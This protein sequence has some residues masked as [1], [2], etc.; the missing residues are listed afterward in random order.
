MPIANPSYYKRKELEKDKT[1]FLF[2]SMTDYNRFVDEVNT[3][4][5]SGN[6][7]TG[8]DMIDAPNTISAKASD[9]SWYGTTDLSLIS[10]NISS[11]LFPSELQ[12]ISSSL[13]SR[14]VKVDVV[15]LDQQKAIKFTEKEVGIFSFDLASLGLIPVYEFYSPL[16]KKVVSGN[17]VIS[18]K[19]ASPY[20]NNLIFYFV[21]TPKIETHE[22]AYNAK[23]GGYY[24]DVL[25]RIVN[26][27][28][29][30]ETKEL[31]F[32]YEGKEAIKK[33]VVE[34]KQVL[35]KKGNKRFATTFKKSFIEIPK[36]TKPLPRIDIIVGA[37]FRAGVDAR[38]Q[39]LY[40][41]LTAIALAEKLSQSGV[42]YRIIASYAFNST[43]RGTRKTIFPFIN[44]KKEGEVLDKNTMAILLADARFNRL[45]RFRGNL[46]MQWD[47]GYESSINPDTISGSIYDDN[48]IKNAY[49]NFLKEQNNPYD[50]ESAKNPNSKVVFSGIFDM[51][52]AIR[53]YNNIINQISRI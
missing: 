35:D 20:P 25:K 5:T 7:R 17:L 30:V 27:T 49:I 12:N 44:L 26:K 46:A 1:T 2:D 39:M 41:G 24:S 31:K 50:V 8:L 18:E 32:I 51:N 22:V 9:A 53:A 16:L 38:N 52:S 13:S 6:A 45:Q 10:D 15:D 47:A 19:T 29:I 36:V 28:E 14:T 37:G 11:F 42:N 43:G 3:L 40:S 21:G 48:E 34:R 4:A 33:H 23:L